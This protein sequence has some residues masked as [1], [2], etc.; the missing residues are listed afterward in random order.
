MTA[1]HQLIPSSTANFVVGS[2]CFDHCC[3]LEFAN[4]VYVERGTSSQHVICEPIKFKHCGTRVV[5]GWTRDVNGAEIPLKIRF[6][7]FDV[8][9]PSMSTCKLR[10]HWYSVLL[11][12]QQTILEDGTTI[13]L[14]DPNGLP[15]LELRFAS[16][17][18]EV[19]EQ[20]C[21][22]VEEIGEEARSATP[23]YVP[24]GPS[25]AERRAHENI[26]CRADLGASIVS[27]VREKKVFTSVERS[28]ATMERSR[29]T[30]CQWTAR[31]CITLQTGMLKSCFFTMVDNSSRSM[32]AT[33]VQ[34]KGHDK[35]VERFLL[36]SLESFGVTGEMVLQTDQETGPIDVAKHVAVE[37][38][39]RTIIR[40]TQEKQPTRRVC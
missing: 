38:K 27:A 9:S 30:W 15:T 35:F 2:G 13:V 20:M 31:S 36:Q 17:P 33:A 34:K 14:T 40:Q 5:E 39:V 28:R 18:G 23:M 32:I 8:K 21:A 7:V 25:D 37:R 12:Q 3:P 26:M 16:R 4:T 24:R 19:D 22:P 6:N 10:Q 29:A 11:D 1:V